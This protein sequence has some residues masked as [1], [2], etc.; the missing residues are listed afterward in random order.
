MKGLNSAGDSSSN[1]DAG[2]GAD[3]AKAKGD[4]T[5][6]QRS[7][8]ANKLINEYIRQPVGKDNRR[9]NRKG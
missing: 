2:K 8:E 3:H 6:G 5:E 9:E 7:K 4:E 1:E